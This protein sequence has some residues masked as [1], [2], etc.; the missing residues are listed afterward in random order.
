LTTPGEEAASSPGVLSFLARLP[1]GALELGG[2]GLG[3]LGIKHEAQGG[4]EGSAQTALLDPILDL[5]ERRDARCDRPRGFRALPTRLRKLG[6]VTS[7]INKPSAG[8]GSVM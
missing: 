4:V 2:H 8:R 7:R 5:A 6:V 1:A 3:W